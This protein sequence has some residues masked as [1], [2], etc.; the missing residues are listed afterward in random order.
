[1]VKRAGEGG[2]APRE[3]ANQRVTPPTPAL[4]V[5]SHQSLGNRM[6]LVKKGA[7][8]RWWLKPQGLTNPPPKVRGGGGGRGGSRRA[9]K[10]PPPESGRRSATPAEVP[11][12]FIE[13]GMP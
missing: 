6:P 7:G 3:T 1:M 4:P 8:K 5:V 13:E 10:R 2:F 12:H 9:A 11:P